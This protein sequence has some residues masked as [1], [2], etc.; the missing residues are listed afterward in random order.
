MEANGKPVFSA[1]GMEVRCDYPGGNVRVLGFNKDAGVV[2]LEPDMRDSSGR[3]F[4]WDFKLSG[5]AGRTLRFQFPDGYEYLSSLGPAISRD[6]GGSWEWLRSDGTRHEPANAF[7]YAFGPGENR[8]RFAMSFPYVQSDW[9]AFASKL[10][11]REDVGFGVLCKSQSGRRDTELL[12]VKCGGKADWLFVFTAR[13]HACEASA[14]PVMEGV[15]EEILS[16]SPEGEWARQNVE[17]VFVPFMDKDGVEDG[18]QGKNRIPHDHNRDYVAG[19]YTSVRA[20]KELVVKETRGRRLV[21]FDLHSPHVRSLPSC[22]EQDNAFS[23]GCADLAQAERWNA[24]RRNWAEAQK[25]G[26]LV[27]DG[28]FDIPAGT[29]FS[30][31]VAKDVERGLVDA[32]TW[33][34]SVPGCFFATTCEFGYSLCGGV[35]SRET[36]RELG[37]NMAK[38]IV[39]TVAEDETQR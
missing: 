17:C 23:F 33:A 14:N 24:F 4:H 6:G 25:G 12:R 35:Y 30:L 1:D 9:D 38:A 10:R 36:A 11:G 21:F 8:T 26:A 22:P 39:R 5:A 32:R 16:G 27:Y 18:D 37:R 2:R 3:W 20:L 28:S 7:E 31:V 34:E 13:H 29:G 15:I 19:L